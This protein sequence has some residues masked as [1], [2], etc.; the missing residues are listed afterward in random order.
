MIA[1][2]TTKPT[3]NPITALLVCLGS[4]GGGGGGVTTGGS[5]LEGPTTGSSSPSAIYS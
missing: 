5:S 4:A 2:K 1:H 3:A